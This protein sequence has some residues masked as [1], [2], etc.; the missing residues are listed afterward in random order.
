MGLPV[1]VLEK[2]RGAGGRMATHRYRRGD[3]ESP[4]LGAQYISTKSSQGHAVLGPVYKRLLDA[5]VLK[6]FEGTVAGP[7]PYGGSDDIRHYTAPEGLQ[8]IA[9]FFLN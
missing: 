5:G 4:D 8:S 2:S 6:T 9:D 7:N 3:R 1:R